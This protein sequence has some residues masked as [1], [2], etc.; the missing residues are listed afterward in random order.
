MKR[1]LAAIVAVAMLLTATVPVSALTAATITTSANVGTGSGSAPTVLAKWEQDL[2]P[3]LEDGNPSHNIAGSQFLPTCVYNTYKTITY[4]FVGKDP[5][6]KA[7][8]KS[9]FVQ[10]FYPVASWM[11][12]VEKYQF[13]LVE[14]PNAIEAAALFDTAIAANLVTLDANT[15]AA[16]V[17]EELIQGT[18]VLYTATADLYYED[19]SGDYTVKAFIYNGNNQADVLENTFLYVPTTCF[20]VDNSAVS[21]GPV[22][23]NVP[24][25]SDGDTLFS[26]GDNKM[27]VRNLGNTN[28]QVKIGQD[29]MGFGQTM[30]GAW[31]VYFDGRMGFAPAR[32]DFNPAAFKGQIY[33]AT[34]VLPGIVAHSSNEKPDSSIHVSIVPPGA[35]SGSMVLGSVIV[36]YV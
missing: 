11:G 29:D 27:T 20:E 4:Y 24:Q 1:I 15:N 12:G 6:G 34:T 9:P 28:M 3:S 26:P 35:Y 5:L 21:Y 19:P 25:Y 7:N 23:P 8:L 10:V 16:F 32:L 33:S 31:K 13:S 22:T 2:T 14:V 17:H 18:S 36:P 30:A